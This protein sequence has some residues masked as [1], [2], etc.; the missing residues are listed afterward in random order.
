V[1]DQCLKIVHNIEKNTK[2]QFGRCSLPFWLYL[3]RTS[4]RPFRMHFHRRIREHRVLGSVQNWRQGLGHA[5]AARVKIDQF[6]AAAWF[7]Q[8]ACRN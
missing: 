4:F 1:G 2:N 3:R 5:M 7:Q 8:F 6:A